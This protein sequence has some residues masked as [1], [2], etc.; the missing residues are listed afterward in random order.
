MNMKTNKD[1]L[2]SILKTTQ[3]G[4]VGIRS[5]QQKATSEELKKALASQLREY[6]S[7]EREAQAIA[8]MRGWVLPELN[9]GVRAMSGMMARAMLT[10]GRTDSKIAGMMIQGNTRGVIKGLKN[11]H[12]FSN[13]D[14][15]VDALSQKLLDRENE[16]IKQME[17]FL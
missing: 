1:L 6:D 4:Q 8:Q 16:N 5:V 2:G 12:Q 11:R 15:R 9:S 3:M 7:I 17:P 14:S 13:R 10:G